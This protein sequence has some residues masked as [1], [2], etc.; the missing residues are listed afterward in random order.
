MSPVRYGSP[1]LKSNRVT[2][3][4]TN[5]LKDRIPDLNAAATNYKQHPKFN[6]K[7][8][9]FNRRRCHV[10]L[11]GVQLFRHVIQAS[12]AD[13]CKDVIDAQ[14]NPFEEMETDHYV[15]Q[16]HGR[17]FVASPKINGNGN[18]RRPQVYNTV[19]YVGGIP[20][21]FDVSLN[22]NG[23]MNPL[24]RDRVNL[25]I[26][27]MMEFFNTDNVGY[28][29]IKPRDLIGYDRPHEEFKESGGLLV[30]M[31]YDRRT[32]LNRVAQAARKHG[33]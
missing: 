14:V 27:P 12:V 33:L 8:P 6:P 10:A 26:R 11:L 31:L 24:R 15:F 5:E 22:G 20:I 3:R 32:Y 30:P 18:G 1:S 21:V 17:I 7:N 2:S 28:V 4:I 19:V 29:V 16:P 23:G 9:K 13:I 25:V